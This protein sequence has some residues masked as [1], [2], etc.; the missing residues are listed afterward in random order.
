MTVFPYKSFPQ[1]EQIPLSPLCFDKHIA[2]NEINPI[3]RQAA[4]NPLD[5]NSYWGN[6]QCTIVCRKISL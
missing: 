6:A 5:L 2:K 4:G 1:R 3:S